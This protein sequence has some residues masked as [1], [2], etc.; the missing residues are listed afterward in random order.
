ML[1]ESTKLRMIKVGEKKP[2]VKSSK[3][4]VKILKFEE[5]EEDE[6]Y[7]LGL[8][9]EPFVPDYHGEWASNK[10]IR[11]ASFGWM[12]DFQD[13]NLMHDV[14]VDKSQI[15]IVECYLSPVDFM[16]GDHTIK[17][18]SWLMGALIHDDE[19]WGDIKSGVYVGWSLEGYATVNEPTAMLPMEAMK[20]IIADTVKSAVKEALPAQK[21][22]DAKEN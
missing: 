3:R 13:L 17:K 2:A 15:T 12:S 21:D 20:S 8:V 22:P 4:L 11:K 10:T 14:K 9:Y 5:G 18:E 6:R 19:L 1:A 16:L 7:V